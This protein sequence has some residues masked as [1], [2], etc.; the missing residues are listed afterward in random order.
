MS[1]VYTPTNLWTEAGR[2]ETSKFPSAA[3]P[4]CCRQIC[5]QSNVSSARV[6]N[7]VLFTVHVFPFLS[8]IVYE[9]VYVYGSSWSELK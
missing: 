4:G 3:T 2:V 5:L 9:Y 1:T 8:F 6:V 7:V